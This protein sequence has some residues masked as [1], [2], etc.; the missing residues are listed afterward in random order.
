[1]KKE[2]LN[3]L[4]NDALIA[5][6]ADKNDTETFYVGRTKHLNDDSFILQ[7][8][9]SNGLIDGYILLRNIDVFEIRKGNLY[10]N[11]LN[12]LI[13]NCEKIIE[14]EKF[15]F[16]DNVEYNIDYLINEYKNREEFISIK[17]IYGYKLTGRIIDYI[18]NEYIYI[19]CFTEDG[20]YD[21]MSL[22]KYED[23]QN[24]SFCGID[25]NIRFLLSCKLQTT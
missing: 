20:I 22:I 4:C 2:I 16:N 25:E 5:I 13:N 15:K 24:L 3:K 18:D 17:S 21:G 12:I 23:I 7:L 14:K 9:T 10:L 8:Y 1:M 6:Y 19:D 11:K